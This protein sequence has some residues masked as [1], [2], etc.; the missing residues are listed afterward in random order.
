[1]VGKAGLEALEGLREG[2]RGAW[3]GSLGKLGVRN[4]LARRARAAGPFGSRPGLALLLGLAAA[5]VAVAFVLYRR[6]RR[7]VNEH[8]NMGATPPG[9][10]AGRTPEPGVPAGSVDAA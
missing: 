8:Y 3:D 9:A 7:Q 6:K 5:L 4:P 10:E 2:A 1:M